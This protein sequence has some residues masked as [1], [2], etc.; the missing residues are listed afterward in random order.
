LPFPKSKN[1]LPVI[2]SQ[3][4]VGRIIDAASDLYQRTIL[5]TLYSTGMR[6]AELTCLKIVDIDSKRMMV[7]INCGKGGKDRDVPSARSCWKHCENIGAG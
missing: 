3:E 2:L 1:R 7:R 6:C 5:M 4:E